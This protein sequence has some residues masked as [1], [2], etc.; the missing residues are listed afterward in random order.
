MSRP[1]VAVVGYPNVG[2][3]T[4]VNR[5]SGTREAVTHAEAGVT[6]DR[7]EVPAEWNGVEFTLVDTG[8]IDLADERSLARD[9][10]QQAR[11]AL[12]D[13]TV[14][15]LV[16]DARAGLRP[17]DAELADI[18][19]RAQPDAIVVA[20]K[21]DRAQDEH[22]TA[23]FYRLGLGDPVAVSAS[24]GLGTG[25]L[26]DR[27]TDT[28][29]AAHS[30]AGA[31]AGDEI[32]LAI[33]GRPNVGKSSLVNA[34][35]GE[36]R[37]IVSERAGTTRDAIDTRVSFDDRSLALV[38]TAGI[39]RRPKVAGSI[40]Y[41][42]QLRSER[43]AERADVAFVV[44]DAAEGV[45]AD[46][47]RI[48][49]LAMRKGCATL[50]VL[51]KW[52]LSQ[53]DLEDAKARVAAKLR[54]RP[55]VLTASAITGRNIARL[56]QEAIALA[57]RARS[58]I[59]TPQLNRFIAEVQSE[60]QP[61]AVRNRRLRIYY[62]S[63]VAVGPPRFKVHVNDRK[64]LVRDYAYFFENR[65]RARYRLEGIPLVIDFADRARRSRSGKSS[66]R[67]AAVEEPPR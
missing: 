58:R 8:G 48:A 61:P 50:I 10:Q 21:L 56:L 4:L 11:L 13:A 63:Q 32:R 45:T 60:R 14:A 54:L 9:V 67:D 17:G 31:H 1:K 34:F 62:A 25:D 16:V 38:D 7:K 46:D 23:E 33:I 6:R 42:A 26:L 22:L 57:D 18:L 66:S 15:L 49:D 51:N 59:S 39:R 12:E 30:I 27:L 65:L 55:R 36:Q 64:L 29:R 44:C 41:Y 43:A 35:L 3:S 20:N 52:D 5:L 37:V 28:L 19:R 24:H 2:K 53:T 47:L 40:D